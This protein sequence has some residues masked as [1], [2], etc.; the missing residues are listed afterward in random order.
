MRRD[1]LGLAIVKHIL[2]T[3]WQQ[4][5]GESVV[6]RGSSVLLYPAEE[7]NRRGL[8]G[9]LL[10]YRIWYGLQERRREAGVF[11]VADTHLGTMVY[12]I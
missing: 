3:P 7:E 11:F 4:N 12:L 8:R 9:E 10:R 6:G 5:P 1:R 2:E